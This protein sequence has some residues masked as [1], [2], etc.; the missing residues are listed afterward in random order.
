MTP[1]WARGAAFG[2]V[3]AGLLSAGSAGAADA[4]LSRPSAQAPGVVAAWLARNT[5][6]APAQ[7]VS[8]GDEYIVAVLSSRPLDPANPRLLRLEMRAEMTDP[9][10]EAA[11]QLRSLSATLDVNC[12]DHTSRFVEVRTFAGANLTGDQRTIHPTEGWT[13]NPRGSYFE[14]IDTAVCT[15]GAPR[16]LM[17]AA[18]APQSAP[19]VTPPAAKAPLALRPAL[20]VDTPPKPAPARAPDPAPPVHPAAPSRTGGEAQIAAAASEAQAQAALDQLRRASPAAMNGLSTRIER[21]ERGGKAYYRA[22]VFG[23]APPASAAAFCRQLTAA[24]H[25]CIA[26]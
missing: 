22:L 11:E 16:P 18:A 19:A 14:N 23:F 10:S 12:A 25:A 26:R 4:T 1:V 5:S 21:I 20:G 6:I 2:A 9:D 15:S 7:V 3:A 8:V 13:A 24:G 17:V